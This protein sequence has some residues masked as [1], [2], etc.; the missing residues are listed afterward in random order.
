MES[1]VDCKS[2]TVLRQYIREEDRKDTTGG[3][4]TEDANSTAELWGETA[5]RWL[6]S[7]RS[8]GIHQRNDAQYLNFVA[9]HVWSCIPSATGDPDS[10][11]AS[12]TAEVY[13]EAFERW[14][15]TLWMI[16]TPS[17]HHRSTQCHRLT[18][19]QPPHDFEVQ[20]A[21]DSGRIHQCATCNTSLRLTF[22]C[23]GIVYNGFSKF[24]HT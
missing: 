13:H 18:T 23:F 20:N 3:S 10:E 24:I 5:E 21:E 9:C 11:Y 17:H 15:T 16:H 7:I 1:G 8:Q 4:W 2:C 6:I 22:W 19:I 12:N 14:T